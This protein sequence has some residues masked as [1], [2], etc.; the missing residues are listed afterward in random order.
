MGPI[1]WLALLLLC[2]FLISSCLTARILVMYAVASKSHKIAVMPIAEELA[3][4]GHQVTVVSPFKPSK[5]VENIHEIVLSELDNPD[6]AKE[7]DWF[8]KKSAGPTQLIQ[9]LSWTGKMVGEG[10][11]VLM[12]NEEFRAIL[13]ERIVDVVIFDAAFNEF[14]LSICDHLKVPYVIH[15]PSS[16][17]FWMELMGVSMDYAFVPSMVTDFDNKMTFFQRLANMAMSEL[18]SQVYRYSVIGMTETT[19]LHLG[20]DLC[21]QTSYQSARFIHGRPNHFQ[22][23][24]SRQVVGRKRDYHPVHWSQYFTSSEE[25]VA[26]EDG[27]TFHIYRRGSSG[28]LLVLLHGG[29]FSALTWSLFAESIEGMVSC[30]VLAIDLRGHGNSKTRNEDNLSAETQAD[31]VVSVVKQVFGSDPPPVILVG[32]SMGGAVAVH[33][34]ASDQ[35]ASLAGLVV[36]D[37]VEGTAMEALASMQNFLRSRPKHFPSL[38]QAIEWSVRSGQI[39]NAVSARV[40]MPG[41]LSNELSGECATSEVSASACS[42]ATSPPPSFTSPIK[43]GECIAEEDE[44]EKVES[45]P[46]NVVLPP[47]PLSPPNPGYRWRIDLTKTEKYW[48]GWFHGLSSTFLGVPVPKLLLL[49]GIDRLDRELTVGQMQGKFQMQVL[50][51][52]GHAVHEDVPD[53]VA[54]VVATFLVRNRLTTATNKFDW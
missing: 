20:R 15:S 41:Q 33:T 11:D 35:L 53:K 23:A 47:P 44:Q 9:M 30:Q 31:D 7:V 48:P 54:E 51:Q 39:R 29:G 49:A 12:R 4:R 40:S 36:I 50:P 27:D 43:H 38:E 14:V 22:R 1:K 52:C 37:V 26:N 21:R 18:F 24:M 34:A 28:P 6:I 16:G 46:P 17:F 10:Y 19:R 3:Q 8:A 5:K 32:H 13:K 25:V 42:P 45:P 2:S